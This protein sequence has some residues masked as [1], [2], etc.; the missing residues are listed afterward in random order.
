[1]IGALWATAARN[2]GFSPAP[3][4]ALMD[5]ALALLAYAVLAYRSLLPARGPANLL[6]LAA[7]RHPDGAV[8][9]PAAAGRASRNTIIQRRS[10]LPLVTTAT[11][12]VLI[13]IF[14]PLRDW[15]GAWI[16][17]RF[18]HREFDY[19]RLLRAVGEDLF[20]RGD[21]K[22]SCSRP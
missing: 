4:H 21:L 3:G 11:I 19:G 2:G 10:H 18:F 22:A 8:Y 20:Q 16:D 15:A 5:L 13:A 17:R 12:I 7:R 1:M 9:Q 6:P 14:G